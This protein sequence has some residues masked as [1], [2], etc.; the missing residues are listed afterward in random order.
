MFFTFSTRAS[1]FGERNNDLQ[2]KNIPNFLK[3]AKFEANSHYLKPLT[4]DKTP[5]IQKCI[6]SPS[7]TLNGKKF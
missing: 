4:E 6:I 1:S 7:L 3:G 5:A 2:F